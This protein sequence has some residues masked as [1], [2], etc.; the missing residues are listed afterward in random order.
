MHRRVEV[1]DERHRVLQR[2]E[3]AGESLLEKE[4]VR[5]RTQFQPGMGL[6]GLSRPSGALAKKT[7]GRE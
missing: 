3:E 2:M 1:S 7:F 4:G 6:R 5:V